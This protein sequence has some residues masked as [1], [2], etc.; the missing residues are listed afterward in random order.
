MRIF[1]SNP[2]KI[3]NNTLNL[4]RD[5]GTVE[6]DLNITLNSEVIFLLKMIFYFFLIRIMNTKTAGY[7]KL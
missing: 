2:I 4:E 5:L 1:N 3:I 7:F 6:N